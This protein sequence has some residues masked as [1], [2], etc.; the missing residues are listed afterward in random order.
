MAIPESFG[1]IGVKLA[2]FTEGDSGSRCD[3][4]NVHLVVS[5]QQELSSPDQADVVAEF[6]RQAPALLSDIV[7]EK[8]LGHP[9]VAV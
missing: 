8:E 9:Q 1:P 3:K 5:W 6:V 2:C 4:S 7:R